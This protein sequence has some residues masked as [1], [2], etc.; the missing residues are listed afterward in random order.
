MNESW[1]VVRAIAGRERAVALLLDEQGIKTFCPMQLLPSLVRGQA[2]TRYHAL[3][4]GYVFAYW[5]TDNA[6]Q[7]YTVMNASGVIDILGG[8]T[9]MRVAPGVVE[10]WIARAGDQDV[11]EDLSKSIADMKRGYKLGDEVRITQGVYDVLSGTVVWIDD[12]K[13]KVGVKVSI[14]GR[15]VVILRRTTDCTLH[16]LAPVSTTTLSRRGY[17]RGGK[18]GHRA[19]VKAFADHIHKNPPT[20]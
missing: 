18:R 1:H 11:I 17:M 16:A 12:A 7:W 8:G 3:F 4:L 19:R 14:F 13:N 15:T 9:P 5:E 20:T 2:Q 10:D 6:H